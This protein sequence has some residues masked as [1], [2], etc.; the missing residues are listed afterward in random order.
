MFVFPFMDR[1]RPGGTSW[2]VAPDS[3]I[4]FFISSEHSLSSIYRC[5][6]RPLS[7][8]CSYN[9]VTA[10]SSYVLVRDVSGSAMM[11]SQS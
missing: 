7:L 11:M 3:L 1:C 5:G 2:C 6:C 8:R 10:R 4:N 9:F